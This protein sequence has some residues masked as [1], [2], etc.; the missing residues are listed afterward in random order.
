MKNC[1]VCCSHFNNP[2]RCIDQDMTGFVGR[3][4]TACKFHIVSPQKFERAE[5]EAALQAQLTKERVSV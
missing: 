3:K 1:Q 5:R 4:D 2:S